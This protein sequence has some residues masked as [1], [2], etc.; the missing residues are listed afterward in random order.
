MV[1]KRITQWLSRTHPWVFNLY[2]VF[3]AFMTYS[4]MYAFRK[5]FAVAMFAEQQFLQI[6]IKIWIISS[7]L[8]GYA[9][10]KF[11]GIKVISEMKIA[12]RSIM[13]LAMVILAEL[14]LFCFAV[15]PG[16]WKIVFLFLN[17][18]PLGLVWGLVFSYLEGRGSTEF[19]GA[20]LSISFIFSSGFVK[21][22]GKWLM[23][24]HH[25]SEYWMPFLTGAL[26]LVP[27][28]IAVYLLD[29]VPPPSAND[30]ALRTQRKP[31]TYKERWRLFRN[32]ATPLSIL[33]FV[34]MLLTAF[35][36][37]RD[38]FSAEMWQSL[39]YGNSSMVFTL[40]EIP[41]AIIVLVIISLV[42]FIKNN[43]L[44]FFINHLIVFFGLLIVGIAT[45]TFEM[46]ILE[47]EYWMILVGL[48]LYL[49]YVPFN[50]IFFD[51]MIASFKYVAN[52]GFLIYL[53]DS[54]GY[55]SSVGILFYKNFGQPQVQ[56][57]NFFMTGA[58]LLSLLG[59]S[60]MILSMILF[61]YKFTSSPESEEHISLSFD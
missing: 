36:D 40:T 14:A 61:Q 33:I 11:I 17:G 48:G 12:N 15:V 54:F 16:N 45:L 35:R 31:M 24:H 43:R 22:A 13:I 1:T 39:G 52:V 56:W 20:G 4:C 44:A 51:R 9:L 49:G 55:L 30:I 19:L 10:S 29:Q 42:M 21:T 6:D 38:N 46:K 2:T 3:A 60:F 47:G 7:Q 53:A 57:L 28:L 23:I 58:Y 34:Y 59:M 32:F 41:I 8:I 25:V 26:F 27:L 37:F 50:S 18:L 5:P